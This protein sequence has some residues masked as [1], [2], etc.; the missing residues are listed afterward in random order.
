MDYYIREL[1]GWHLSRTANAKAAEAALEEAQISRYG[2]LGRAKDDLTMRSDDL[3]PTVL[4]AI[5][6]SS[7]IT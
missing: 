1:L 6:N 3:L 5:Q 2:V 7:A 4:M